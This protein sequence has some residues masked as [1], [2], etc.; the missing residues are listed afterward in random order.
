MPRSHKNSSSLT[1]I[2]NFLVFSTRKK[3]SLVPV[4]VSLVTGTEFSRS[5]KMFQL[6]GFFL[7]LLAKGCIIKGSHLITK[8]TKTKISDIN[9]SFQF[10]MPDLEID[11]LTIIARLTISV[12]SSFYENLS[13]EDL[14][15]VTKNAFQE[16]VYGLKNEDSYIS[17]MFCQRISD[18]EVHL[19]Y[20]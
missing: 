2:L 11:M 8:K 5:E 9:F 13:D 20:L 4:S 19:T 17:E 7:Q 14:E 16:L 12:L 1:T 3:L 18:L 6:L 15:S 10:N